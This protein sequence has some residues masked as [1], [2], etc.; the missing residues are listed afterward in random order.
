M[1][2]INSV[3]EE[4]TAGS[5]SFKN[6]G[7]IE[8]SGKQKCSEQDARSSN[9]GNT[10]LEMVGFHEVQDNDEILP[11]NQRRE[12]RIQGDDFPNLQELT[13]EEIQNRRDKEEDDDF[14]ENIDKV[15]RDGDLSPRQIKLL[16]SGAKRSKSSQHTVP[17]QVKTRS[18]KERSSEDSFQ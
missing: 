12:N 9:M 6:S 15:V 4:E 7:N 17:L 2:N 10:Y 13:W 1:E 5:E 14:D 18:S 8:V 11:E 3:D 16:E